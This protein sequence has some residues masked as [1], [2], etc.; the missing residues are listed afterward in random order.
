VVGLGIV[1][2]WDDMVLEVV[3]RV[4][5]VKTVKILN[6]DLPPDPWQAY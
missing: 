6:Q 5:G 1:P 2:P 3:R 4:K